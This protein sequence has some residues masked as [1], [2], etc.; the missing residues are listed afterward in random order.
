MLKANNTS[1]IQY[2]IHPLSL[3]DR[4]ELSNLLGVSIRTLARWAENGTGPKFFKLGGIVKYRIL[5][6]DEWVTENTFHKESEYYVKEHT[7]QSN[8][9]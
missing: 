7:N 5:D 8:A 1:N 9:S 2:P 3:L 4:A 6:V